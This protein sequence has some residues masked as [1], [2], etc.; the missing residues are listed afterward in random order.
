MEFLC[1][2]HSAVLCTAAIVVSNPQELRFPL[3]CRVPSLPR[4]GRAVALSAHT[5]S[6]MCAQHTA[7]CR[8][9]ASCKKHSV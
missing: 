2:T 1:Q 6:E 9:I 5:P 7:Q 4:Q 3:D 8:H